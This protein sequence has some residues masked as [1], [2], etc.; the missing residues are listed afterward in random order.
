MRPDASTKYLPVAIILLCSS[1][2]YLNTLPGGFVYD[3]HFFIENNRWIT[4]PRFIAEIFSTN[5][6][7]FSESAHSNYYRPLVHLILM[8]EHGLFG[9]TPWGYHLANLCLHALNSILVFFIAS[10]LFSDALERGGG[11]AGG[12]PGAAFGAGSRTAAAFAAALIFAL[13]P[14]HVEAVAPASVIAELAL[15][16]FYLAAFYL[17]MLSSRGGASTRGTVYYVLSIASFSAAVFTKETSLSLIAVL[18]A[19]DLIICRAPGPRALMGLKPLRY[20]PYAAAAVFYL[21]VRYHALGGMIAPFK[22][23]AYLS[24]AQYLLNV[25]P[26]LLGY[27]RLLVWPAGLNAFHSFEPV[28]SIAEPKAFASVL[29]VSA[30]VALLLLLRSKRLL[31]F[32]AVWAVLSLAPAL[33][34]PGVGA[35][36]AV[37]AERYLYIPSMGFAVFVSFLLGYAYA[38]LPG[39]AKAALVGAF[40]L[41]AASLAYLTVERNAVWR[42]DYSLWKDTVQKTS[43]SETVYLNYGSAAAKRGRSKEAIDAFTR[44]LGVNP[45]SAAAYLNLGSVYYGEKDFDRAALF[46]TRALALA[47]DKVIMSK[48]HE[49]LGSAYLAK[50]MLD[51]ARREYGEAIGL[52]RRTDNIFI[53]LGIIYAELGMPEKAVESFRE[54]LSINPENM[55]ARADLDRALRLTGAR[56]GD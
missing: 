26:V 56:D 19:Y 37:M 41:G 30:A 25:F 31:L 3:D 14:V 13:H 29:F 38:R 21:A 1:A 9:L 39:K 50:G 4:S 47:R 20:L 8:A 54:A 16:L 43:G 2:V 18:A 36:G 53:G 24:P 28:Y 40:F 51:M 23:Y 32:S 27:G 5:M 12:G 45:S 35:R 6:W 10:S 48:A 34:L 44:A 55:D 22:Q 17:Y 49:S 46:L 33:Y 11:G 7:G 42:D 52:G 15:A